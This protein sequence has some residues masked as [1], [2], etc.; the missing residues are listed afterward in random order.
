MARSLS[1][2]I[3]PISQ[4]KSRRLP[5]LAIIYPWVDG[6]PLPIVLVT[7]T[8]VALDTEV[9]VA[10]LSPQNNF[11]ISIVYGLPGIYL[12]LDWYA[13]PLFTM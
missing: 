12:P 11:T 3:Q 6:E 10:V 4:V 7:S 8:V 9:D 1:I 2:R 5:K 13:I